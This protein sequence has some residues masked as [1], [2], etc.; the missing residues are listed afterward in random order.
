VVG[1]D[2]PAANGGLT[3]RPRFVLSTGRCGS[4]LLGGL[5]GQIPGVATM[6]EFFASIGPRAFARDSLDGREL[7]ELLG[8]PLADWSAALAAHEEPSEFR[9]PVDAPGAR[10]DRASGVPAIAAVCLPTLETEPDRALDE[11][12]VEVQTFQRRPVGVQYGAVLDLLA[13]RSGA[14]AWVERSGGSLGYATQIVAAFPAAKVVH[15]HRD[16][17]ETALSM[18]G[19]RYFREMLTT[20]RPGLSDLSPARFGALWSTMIVNGLQAL[21]R[22]PKDQVLHVAYE[23]LVA[24]PEPTLKSVATFF[25]IDEPPSDW[26]AAARAQ[27][28][29]QPALT[30]MVSA[31]EYTALDL[32]CRSGTRRLRTVS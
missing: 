12:Q 17:A 31:D 26:Y 22:L 16:G 2:D 21:D 8:T 6:S 18:H 11:L 30:S 4:T 3:V 20:L 15:L 1:C 24:E 10:Y 5:L 23:Q 14:S 13:Q 29:R 25:D 19:H 28:V 27:I 7:W 32:A 9:Y